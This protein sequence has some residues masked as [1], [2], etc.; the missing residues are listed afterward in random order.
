MSWGR[1][2]GRLPFRAWCL[3]TCG[4]VAIVPCASGGSALE[5]RPP[6]WLR[7]WPRLCGLGGRSGTARRSFGAG[8]N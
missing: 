5:Q 2:M 3:P 8:Q 6:A 4:D 7:R 1:R